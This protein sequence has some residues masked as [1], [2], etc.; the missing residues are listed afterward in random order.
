[1]S[2][3]VALHHRLDG[4]E[5]GEVLVLSN[6]LGTDLRMWDPQI[7]ALAERYRVLRYDHRGHGR[8]PVPDGPYSIEDLGSDVLALLDALGVSV[9]HVCGLSIGGLVGMWLGAHA[10]ERI[11]VLILC[12]T[13]PWFGPPD[14]W[15]ER[16][17]AVREGGTGSV[18]D[19]VVAR[20]FTPAF[21]ARE[22]R[23]VA[24]MRDMLAAMPAEG[25]AA[26][27]EVV[28]TTDLRPELRAIRAPTLVVAGADDDAVPPERVAMLAEGID[29][30]RVAW[31]P[32]AAHLANI[33][34]PAE[35]TRHILDHLREH[36]PEE[37]K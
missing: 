36:L 27:C 4:P 18:A 26:C 22:P 17:A 13:S 24:G 34:Q 15:F 12:C 37:A 16:A 11:G 21:A 5:D 20:W 30:A 9:A 7:P 1:M 28:G 31:V 32:D 10:P 3:T 2:A 25:Y 14:P 23:V 29:G 6:S 8:S 35:V 33:E 19:R